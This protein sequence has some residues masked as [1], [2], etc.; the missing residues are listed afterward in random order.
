MARYKPNSYEQGKFIP[1]MTRIFLKIVLFAYSRW[2]VS[3][4]RIVQCCEEDIIFMALSTDTRR[5]FTTISDFIAT[6]DKEIVHLF[7]DVLLVCDDLGLIGKEMFAID[8]CKLP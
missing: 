4:G 7:R 8:G 1:I 5:H 3:S 2:I 6:M